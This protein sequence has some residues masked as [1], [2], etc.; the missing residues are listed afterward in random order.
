MP[1]VSGLPELPN[2]RRKHHQIIQFT[3]SLVVHPYLSETIKL[4]D[5]HTLELRSIPLMT[6]HHHSTVQGY[7]LAV[8]KID[9]EGTIPPL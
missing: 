8:P 6:G 1:D 4:L 9:L 2:R 5:F 3:E 7:N